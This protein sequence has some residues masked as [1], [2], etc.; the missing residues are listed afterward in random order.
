VLLGKGDGTFETQVRYAV[1]SQPTS[2]LTGDFDGDGRLDLAVLNYGSNDVSLL[3]GNGDGTFRAQRRSA[4]VSQPVGMVASDFNNDGWLDLAVVNNTINDISLLLGT[5]DGKFLP[6]KRLALEAGYYGLTAADFNGDGAPPAAD[7]NN[8]GRP[9]QVKVDASSDSV[10]ISLGNGDGT[11]VSSSVLAAAPDS[12]PLV[13]DWNG[14]GAPDVFELNS[15]GEILYRQGRPGGPGSFDAP[16]MLAPGSRFLS[17]AFLRTPQG[18]TLAAVNEGED[19]VSLFR[20]QN[21][22]FVPVGTFATGHLPAQIVAGDLNGDGWDDLVVRNAGDGTLSLY[23]SA[24]PA[25]GAF[26]GRV[27]S[28]TFPPSF[29]SPSALSVGLGAS[30][31]S[32]A[33]TTGRGLLD[34]IV[35]N[36]STGQVSV[37]RNLGDGTFG[38]AERYRAGT[39]ASGL[40]SSSGTPTVASLDATS[41]V[42]AGRFTAGGA[43]D[44]VTLDPGSNTMALLAGLGGGRFANPVNLQIQP[45]ATVVR[46]ADFDHDGMTDLAILGDFGLRILLGDG[47]GGFKPPVTYDVGPSATSLSIADV[48]HDHSFDLVVGDAFGDV[49]VLLGRGDGTFQPYRKLDQT[50]ALAVADLDGNGVP[51]FVFANQGLDQVTVDYNDRSRAVVADHSSGLI[52]PGAVVLADLNGDGIKDLIVA[53]SG[54]NSIF[55]YPRLGNGQFGTALNDGH[56]FFAGT[57]PTG[58]TVADVNGDGKPD[59]IVANSGS[60]DVSVL[61]GQGTGT[62][63]T[64]V[65][66]PRIKTAAGPVSTVVADLNG[67]GRPDLAVANQQASSVQIFPGVGGGFFNDQNPTTIPVGSAPGSIFLGNF[68]GRPDLLTVNAGSNDL[69]LIS[70]YNEPNPVITTISSGGVD[71]EAAFTFAAATGF[72]DLV[73]GN[74]DDGILALFEGGPDG[75]TL[76]STESDP[77]LPSPTAL[78][79]ATLTGGEVQFYAAT[80]GRESA[81]L[82][83]FSF[84]GETSGGGGGGGGTTVSTGPV[85]VSLE[86]S[87]LALV[88]TFLVLTVAPS[89]LEINVEAAESE[90]ASAVVASAVP[91][92]SIGQSLTPQAALAAENEDAATSDAAAALL[93][94]QRVPG[95][96]PWERFILGLDEALE[97]FRREH[98][99]RESKPAREQGKSGKVE[100]QPAARPHKVEGPTSLKSA[101]E[102]HSQPWRDQSDSTTKGR[103]KAQVIDTAIRSLWGENTGEMP[104]AAKAPA[105]QKERSLIEAATLTVPLSVTIASAAVGF[106]MFARVRQRRRKREGIEIVIHL[107]SE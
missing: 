106:A 56:G 69:T 54:S 84:G 26:I 18:P 98:Q 4:V 78:A 35:T 47:K 65:P 39:G 63:W 10:T 66:G 99:N 49:L 83:A 19:S 23:L 42:A 7:F 97:Q 85:L 52:A 46:A 32:L 107:R 25:W 31:V 103:P 34:L 77:N 59:L 6:E 80:E 93:P 82:V 28:R 43:V 55:V 12:T 81:E 17:I 57:N 3:L 90:A 24:P 38:R 5:G 53:N 72:D 11:Y 45:G 76:F 92:V 61:L 62:S 16:I 105:K 67:D 68:D 101:P 51:D 64:L 79:F 20:S 13:A 102:G 74:H 22:H 33:D 87:P 89:E 88:A 50:V 94:G 1:G 21:G 60:N 40:D 95:A 100:A 30:D 29:L 41:G 71:P 91:G 48:N 44:L 75:L 15:A 86:E 37:L 27:I 2:I 104:V 8:D 96:T 9:D 70:N 58:V 73:V 36:K 14:D